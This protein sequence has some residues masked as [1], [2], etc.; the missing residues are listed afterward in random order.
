MLVRTAL[1]RVRRLLVIA[2]VAFCAV[3]GIGV[4]A[5]VTSS[6]LGRGAALVFER[7]D[8]LAQSVLV[9]Y[10]RPDSLASV[11]DE[12]G[13]AIAAT[14]AGTG[15]V[16]TPLSSASV[17]LR[18]D[19]A[20][21]VRAE[22][23]LD[24][25]LRSEATLTAGRWASDAE[26]ATLN[27]AAAEALGM[28][29]GSTIQLAGVPFTV[30]GLWQPRN[31]AAA[32]WQGDPAV[33]SG[34]SADG[35]GPVLVTAAGVSAVPAA[36]DATWLIVP[37]DVTPTRVPALLR[38][39]ETLPSAID[40]LDPQGQRS[41]R[42]GGD[43]EQTL[44]RITSASASVTGTVVIPLV[45]VF[46]LG[47]IVLWLL[48]G[49]LAE[50]RREHLVLLRARGSSAARIGAHAGI[51]SGAVVAIAA[52]VASAI[53]T[54]FGGVVVAL[55]AAAVLTVVGAVGAA[56][57]AIRLA[58]T[59]SARRDGG[60]ASAATL[61]FPV[62]F[63]G[64]LAA[65]A[66][67]QL[68]ARRSFTAADGTVDVAAVAAPALLLI[69]GGLIAAGLAGPAA[70]LAQY[71]AARGRGIVAVLPLRRIARSASTLTAAVLSLALAA[72]TIVLGAI[73]LGATERAR[74]DQQHRVLAADMRLVFVDETGRVSAED[75]R[76]AVAGVASVES[77]ASALVTD[78]TMGEVPARLVVADAAWLG[79]AGENPELRAATDLPR[80]QA[81][82]QVTFTASDA[83]A[84]T[85]TETIDGVTYEYEIPP[86]AVA[87][88]LI[89]QRDDGDVVTREI[90]RA[91]ADGVAHTV[92]V[93]V[94]AD[95]RVMGVSVA[96]T[97]GGGMSADITAT[98]T[99]TGAGGD[100][101]TA[102]LSLRDRDLTQRML[103]P[104]L[105]TS[106]PVVLTRALADELGLGV[107]DDL[108]AAAAALNPRLPVT[109]VGITDTIAG[110][111]S[112]RA[113]AADLATLAQVQVSASGSTPRPD[114]AWVR[115]ADPETAALMIRSTLTER[116]AFVTPETTSTAAITSVT[117]LAMII[118]AIA[119]VVLAVFGFVGVI[120]ESRRGRASSIIALRAVGMT[121]HVQHR[122]DRVEALS[123]AVFALV[124]GTVVGLAVAAVVAPIFTGVTA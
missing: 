3:A 70:W 23:L 112:E 45:V 31:P 86:G 107:G 5:G 96:A 40:D 41:S 4:T 115:T 101:L 37:T 78:I 66:T 98:V 104:D 15:A 90:A 91:V 42:I 21:P 18:G 106:L 123:I 14:F 60:W 38:A 24:A 2:L 61:G 43:L 109:V 64:I 118:A 88:S 74:A 62:V 48:I 83:F 72:G 33:A 119:T 16:V 71:V 49:G 34:A 39:I 27:A 51:E 8:P 19:D 105:P 68:L 108:V 87:V 67:G 116:A 100:D 20:D 120:A 47:T 121:G 17:E 22:V 32:I 57:H 54:V 103:V 114:Q 50:S 80:P 28:T 94:A 73:V 110:A 29:A 52:L 56:W 69:V 93:V 117:A 58:R 89:T 79:G 95:E 97:G 55:A 9:R 46:A 63:V 99:L 26:E 82:S 81:E 76:R 85:I 92:P 77:V 124:A 30:T 7:A 13:Q 36:F 65:L 25:A 84:Q 6:A 111:G 75:R 53:A 12:Y 1:T 113:V 35:V 59:T 102:T 10:A 44:H 122:A 11:D